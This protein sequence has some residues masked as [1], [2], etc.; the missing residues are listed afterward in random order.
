MMSDMVTNIILPDLVA[1][2]QRVCT[3]LN[4]PMQSFKMSGVTHDL[5]RDQEQPGEIPVILVPRDV[6]RDLPFASSRDEIIGV[7]E[8]NDACAMG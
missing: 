5:P 1:C 7:V 8:Y 6:L 4:I 3:S 2:T